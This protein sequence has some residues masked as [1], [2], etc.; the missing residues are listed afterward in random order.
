MA[1]VKKAQALKKR[2]NSE[3]TLDWLGCWRPDR[4]DPAKIKFW[5]PLRRLKI[6]LKD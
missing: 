1:S 6:A 5:S 3:G 4:F 2:D